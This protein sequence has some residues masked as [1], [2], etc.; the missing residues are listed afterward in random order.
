MSLNFYENGNFNN[1]V[2]NIFA[3]DQRGQHKR[4]GMAILSQNLISQLSKIRENKATRNF[5]VYSSLLNPII[6]YCILATQSLSRLIA[7]YSLISLEQSIKS[8]ES[9]LSKADSITTNN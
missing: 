8:I 7:P 9:E 1:F 3:N 6:N 4:C 5:P 2:K